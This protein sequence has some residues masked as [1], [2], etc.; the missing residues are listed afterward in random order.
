MLHTTDANRSYDKGY[1]HFVTGYTMWTMRTLI[2][3]RANIHLGVK[4]SFARMANANCLQPTKFGGGGVVAEMFRDLQKPTAF[5]GGGRGVVADIFR[6]LQRVVAEMF[7]VNC[8]NR[9]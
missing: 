8:N 5:G 6:D 4:P 7:S 2:G 9:P 1:L 3:V